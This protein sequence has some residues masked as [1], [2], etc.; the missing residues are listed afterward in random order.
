MK[1]MFSRADSAEVRITKIVAGKFQP[2]LTFQHFTFLGNNAMSR[3]SEIRGI[4]KIS[5]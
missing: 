1:I 2:T 3:I 4:K 5:R